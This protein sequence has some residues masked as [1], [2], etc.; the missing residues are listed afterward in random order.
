M[1]KIGIDLGGTKIEG[2]LL[3]KQNQVMERIRVPTKQE[4][5]YEAILSRIVTL[6][7]DIQFR[8]DQAASIG[9]CTPGAIEPTEGVLKNSNTVCLNGK[10]LKDD[11]ESALDCSIEMENDANCFALAEAPW[12]PQKGI[13][14]FSVSSWAPAWVAELFSASESTGEDYS[15]PGNGVTLHCIPMGFIVT[16]VDRA[17]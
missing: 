15:L 16:A 6:I 2:I 17:V 12:G 4:N 7:K 1:N 13:A 3:D 14:R 8:S 5:G 11:L 10:P 9:I